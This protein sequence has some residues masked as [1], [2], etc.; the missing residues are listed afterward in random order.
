MFFIFLEQC[1]AAQTQALSQKLTGVDST[2]MDKNKGITRC[3]FLAKEAEIH[4]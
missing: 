4:F 3:G 2:S 1:T